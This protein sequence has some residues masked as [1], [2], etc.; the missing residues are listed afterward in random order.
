M[1]FFNEQVDISEIPQAEVL[2]YHALEDRYKSV[3]YLSTALFSLL[4]V[5][6]LAVPYFIKSL[7]VAHWVVYVIAVFIIIRAI[8][9]FCKIFFGFK[10]KQYALRE[11][12]IIYQTGWLWRSSTIIPFNRVQHVSVDQGPIERKFKLSKIKIFT[13]GGSSSDLSIPGLDPLTANKLK[14]FIVRKTAF[15]EEE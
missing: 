11:K 13:A 6:F 15:D 8:V 1:A 9:V 2:S 7:N 10:Y 14:D 5:A 3:L 12:D 4:A